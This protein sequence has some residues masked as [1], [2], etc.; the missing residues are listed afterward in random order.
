MFQMSIRAADNRWEAAAGLPSKRLQVDEC[1]ECS[2]SS[3]HTAHAST[4]VISSEHLIVG[5]CCT[6]TSTHSK[7]ESRRF[8]IGYTSMLYT[9]S[10]CSYVHGRNSCS[11]VRGEVHHFTRVKLLGSLSP[12]CWQV[13]TIEVPAEPSYFNECQVIYCSDWWDTSSKDLW[14]SLHHILY[15]L[16]FSIHLCSC[17]W[18]SP[19]IFVFFFFLINEGKMITKPRSIE[20]LPN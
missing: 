15:T 1:D 6:S 20:L 4:H 8:P 5:H 11:H 16:V 19:T 10:G 2:E 7:V 14:F 3:S 17:S 12:L 9:Y 18:P 13:S